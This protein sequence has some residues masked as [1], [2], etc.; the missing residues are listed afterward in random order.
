MQTYPLESLS[1]EQAIE[2]QFKIVD[3]VTRHFSGAQALSLGDLG[4]KLGQNKPDATVRAEKVFADV[5]DAERALLVRGAGTGALRWAFLA[6]TGPNQ[7]VLIHDA[8]IYPTTKI[9][10][11]SMAAKYLRCDFNDSEALQRL[12]SDNSTKVSAALVQH[13]RQRAQDSYDFEAVIRA[14]KRLRPSLPV[15]TDD[16]YAALKT[17]GIGCQFGADIATFSCFKILG[18]EGVGVLLGREEYIKK[19]YEMQYSGGSQVQGHEAMA[20][21]RGLIYAP[22]A[23]AIE[24]QVIEEL[25]RRLNAGELEGVKAAYIAN[26]QS[27]ILLVE[28]ENELAPSVIEAAQKYGAAPHPVGSESRYEFVPMIYRVSGTFREQDPSLEKRMLR[29]NPM[30]AGADTV[31][32]ILREAIAEAN[33]Q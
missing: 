7:P 33:T 27:K 17:A 9:T 30:R 14:I 26:S 23:L 20:A 5:F 18:P 8:P 12:L 22:V 13:T 1:I 31:L 4:V 15:V 10:L 11:D 32:R 6:V 28:L 21:L 19:A 25:R 24:A 29:I 3:A 16:N 2:L